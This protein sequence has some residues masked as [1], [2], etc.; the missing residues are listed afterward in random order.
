MNKVTNHRGLAQLLARGDSPDTE[1]RIT[2]GD[3]ERMTAVAQM[4][5]RDE[6]AKAALTGLIANRGSGGISMVQ[7]AYKYADAALKERNET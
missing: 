1:V 5:L 3:L 6:F 7:T 2:L 4:N